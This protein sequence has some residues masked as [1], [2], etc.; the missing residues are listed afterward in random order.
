MAIIK[1]IAKFI[2]QFFSKRYG[3]WANKYSVIAG[4]WSGSNSLYKT[5]YK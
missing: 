3:K 1:S 2:R 4:R 5:R